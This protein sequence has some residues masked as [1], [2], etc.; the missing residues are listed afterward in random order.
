MNVPPKYY[1]Y[2]IQLE[3][4]CRS[5]CIHCWDLSHLWTILP[6]NWFYNKVNI[7]SIIYPNQVGDNSLSKQCIEQYLCLCKCHCATII[8]GLRSHIYYLSPTDE[9]TSQCQI[10]SS[11][12]SFLLQSFWLNGLSYS[13]GCQSRRLLINTHT[14]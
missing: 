1:F 9:I 13:L 6:T 2:I 12:A 8:Q 5:E 3:T 4:C 14:N 11:T 10:L 7:H